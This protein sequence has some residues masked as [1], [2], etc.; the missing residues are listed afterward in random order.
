VEIAIT[1]DG[2][3][4]YVTDSNPVDA[5][6]QLTRID[7]MSLQV[8]G[9]QLPPDQAPAHVAISPD[10]KDLYVAG[11][12]NFFT[13]IDLRTDQS[14]R[15]DNEYVEHSDKAASL[16][17]APDGRRLVFGYGQRLDVFARTVNPKAAGTTMVNF[18]ISRRGFLDPAASAF[19]ERYRDDVYFIGDSVTAGFGY[20]GAADGGCKVNN[21]MDNSW[22]VRGLGSTT[23]YDCA[24]PD[25][26]NP[27]TDDC[28]NNNVA[29]GKP[30]ESVKAWEKVKGAPT[31]AYSFVIANFQSPLNPAAVRNWAMTGST[32]AHWDPGNTAWDL[33]PGLYADQLKMITNSYVVMTLGANPLL[34][35]YLDIHLAL[36]SFTFLKKEFLRPGVCAKSTHVETKAA[37][38]NADPAHASEGDGVGKCFYDQWQE[39]QQELHLLNIYKTLLQNGNRVVVVGYPHVPMVIW[40]VAKRAEYCFRS[41]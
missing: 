13:S 12:A 24:P 20:C 33:I 27:P 14:R 32:P 40:R 29:G 4:A 25:D 7:L 18:M 34:S 10:G 28:S 19:T 22:A 3:R 31:I 35:T 39:I 6:K 37:V 41:C 16:A 9:Q 17:I 36:P 23:L 11:Y 30:W 1:P 8:S 2:Q 15:I 21:E 38:L 5:N 26:P